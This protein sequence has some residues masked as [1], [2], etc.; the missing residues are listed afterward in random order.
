MEA[1]FTILVSALQILLLQEDPFELSLTY[2]SISVV[3]AADSPEKVSLSGT[4][5]KAI[6]T[7]L[8][9]QLNPPKKSPTHTP[10]NPAPSISGCPHSAVPSELT[11]TDPSLN[12]LSDI[13]NGTETFANT[14]F[15]KNIQTNDIINLV[16][17]FLIFL[18]L[19][20]DSINPHFFTIFCL[21]SKFTKLTF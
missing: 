14:L 19:K 12:R 15:V 16:T 1:S 5:S 13:V 6:S 17:M 4:P 10:N 9:F 3:N 21:N 20:V 8:S 2:H 18:S 11:T 7:Y